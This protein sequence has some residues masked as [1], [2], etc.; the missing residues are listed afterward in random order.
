VVNVATNNLVPSL[1][2]PGG[3]FPLSAAGPTNGL[4]AVNQTNL[5]ALNLHLNAPW[6]PGQPLWLVWSITDNSGSG[7]GYGIDNLTFSALV[8]PITSP[9]LGSVSYSGGASGTGLRLGFSD[10]PGASGQFTVWYTT[11][12]MVPFS[13][14]QNLGHPT[15]PSSGNYLFNDV[16]ATNK[17][18]RF[19]RVTSP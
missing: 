7:Q 16:Q 17:P 2:I 8:A 10:S 15:E 4:L 5:S 11:N 19:Y 6:A 18:V 1:S 13:Q 9:T 12:L 3:Y 14:W